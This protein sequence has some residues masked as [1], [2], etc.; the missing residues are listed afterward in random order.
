MQ[1]ACTRSGQTFGFA[2]QCNAAGDVVVPLTGLPPLPQ[3]QP[4][5]SMVLTARGLLAQ[6]A[7][8]A[9]DTDAQKPLLIAIGAGF[10]AQQTIPA[11]RGA[12]NTA[13]SLS[14]AAITLEE[15]AI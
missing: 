1:L 7:A 10:A 8:A 9:A 11:I 12:F 4:A 14:L 5:D 3:G 2:G 13:A 6:A 15:A